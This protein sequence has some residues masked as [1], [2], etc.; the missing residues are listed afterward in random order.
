MELYEYMKKAELDYPNGY[1][2]YIAKNPDDTPEAWE[3]NL[4]MCNNRE[5]VVNKFWIIKTFA[6]MAEWDNNKLWTFL[7]WIDYEFNNIKEI[8]KGK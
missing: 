3:L 7:G 1:A 2:D 5:M 4:E 8:R 6:D